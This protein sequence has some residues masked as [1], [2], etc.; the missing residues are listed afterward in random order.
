[1]SGVVAAGRAP[2]RPWPRLSLTGVLLLELGAVSLAI[3]VFVLVQAPA[4]FQ[5]F[6]PYWA[7]GQAVVTRQPL[8]TAFLQHPFPDPVLR[9][10]FIY[11]P[12]F[13]LLPATLSW[14]PEPTAKLVW[15]L[16]MQV[17]LA[18][19]GWFTYRA[20]GRPSPSEGLIALILT[21]NFYPLLVDLWQGQVNTFLLAAAAVFL[22]GVVRRH[23]RVMGAVAAVGGAVKIVPVLWLA[24]AVLTRR[25]A[26]LAWATLA[27]GAIL[28]AG[29][30][31]TGWEQSVTYLTRVLPMLQQG[32]AFVPNQ[33]AWGLTRR[34]FG[35]DHF[36]APPWRWDGAQPWVSLAVCG[37]LAGWWLRSRQAAGAR[38]SDTLDFA[39]LLCLLLLVASTSWEHHFTLLLVPMWVALRIVVRSGPRN[40][41]LF[42][43]AVFYASVSVAPRLR[44]ILPPGAG[45]VHWLSDNAV[46]IGTVILFFWLCSNL[47]H[48]VPSV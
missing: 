34:L 8:Y 21:A 2:T 45:A 41:A 36:V 46:F 11:P 6:A 9:P 24:L 22:W 13:A 18:T 3:Y 4:H 20:L 29:M 5:D 26:A 43:L 38:R 32:T 48:P 14:L 1:M 17:A 31:A 30:L 44:P 27:G 23:D 37:A 25:S 39:A 15:L 12:P 35:P 10:A 33:S 7:A 47:R 42:T 28:A 16:A 40:S 19:A